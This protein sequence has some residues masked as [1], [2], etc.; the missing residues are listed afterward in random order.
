MTKHAFKRW[1][2]RYSLT[3]VAGLGGALGVA[4]AVTSHASSASPSP[5]AIVAA[6]P[7]AEPVRD[8]QT[9]TVQIA[10]LLDTSSSMDG[11]INQARS[12][13][14]TMVDQMGH[15]TR[16]VDG[17]TR[18]VKVELALYQYGND[19]LAKETGWIQQVTPFTSDLDSVS[20]KLNGLFTNGGSEYVGQ[21][22]DT[23]VAQLTWNKD[24]AM[25]LIYVAGNEEFDQGPVNAVKAMGDAAQKDIHVQL[26]FCGGTEPTWQAAAKVAQTDLM[27]IDQDHVAKYIPAPQDAEITRLGQELNATYLAYGASGAASVARQAKADVVAAKMSPK[28]AV[29]RMQLKAKKA[30]SN[31]NWDLVDAQKAKPTFLENAKDDDLPEQMR[32]KTLDEKKAIVAQATAA[33]DALQKQLA[34]LEAERTAFLAAESAKGGGGDAPS[35]GTELTKSAKK[36]AA[37]KGF[38]Y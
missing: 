6:A 18:G 29:E 9:D 8:T 13:L 2:H 3:L 21:A 12:Q 19:T 27:A 22:I 32:G 7:A 30:Y 11:L 24:A 16:V 31:S 34:K 17:K 23:A 33:R 28:V 36:V 38:A 4:Y 26:I 15:M 1:L 37:K 20:E 10:I 35:L 25:K 5:A 14:W